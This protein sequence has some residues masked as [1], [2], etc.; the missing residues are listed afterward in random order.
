MKWKALALLFMLV[1]STLPLAAQGAPC[2]AIPTQS[3]DTVGPGLDPAPEIGL[4]T[5]AFEQRSCF[6]NCVSNW[7]ATMCSGLTGAEFQQCSND[8]AEGCRCACGGYCP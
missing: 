2:L 7:N 1:L 8:G 6:M 3:E 4:F 5:P